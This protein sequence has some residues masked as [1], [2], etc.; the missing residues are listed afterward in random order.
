MTAFG[1]DLLSGRGGDDIFWSYDEIEPGSGNDA[2]VG[3]LGADRHHHRQRRSTPSASTGWW[4]ACR[5]MR[6]V[7]TDFSVRDILDVSRI[8][9]DQTAPGDQAFTFIGDAAVQR[10]GR[11]AALPAAGRR[12]LLV[13]A[14][15]DGDRA[16]PTWQ[17][18][19][20]PQPAYQGQALTRLTAGATCC[21]EQESSLSLRAFSP[22]THPF[23]RHSRESGDL[24]AASDRARSPLSRG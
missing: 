15:A 22:P 23:V 7:V 10:H 17:V 5:G 13:S 3:G 24:V 16:G 4:R 9:A 18:M 11:R 6:T 8:D 21:S 14:D 19:L 1:D 2:F 12:G 20:E